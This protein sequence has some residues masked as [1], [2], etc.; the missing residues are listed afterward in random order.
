MER[1]NRTSHRTVLALTASALLVLTSS[2]AALARTQADADCAAIAKELRS[3][4]AAAAG[5]SL[6]IDNVD[7]AP[8]RSDTA[9]P[10]DQV[11]VTT[12]D[13]STPLL[14]LGPRVNNA[15]QDIFGESDNETYGDQAANLPLPPVAETDEMP[16]PAE[17]P[18]ETDAAADVDDDI[19]LPLLQ[20]QMYRTDI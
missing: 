7:H 20:R 9:P 16:E 10:S 15:M 19:D 4:D 8:L 17:L 1:K 12:V 18:A 2:G 13:L 3:L 6:E 11:D 14:R 5:P